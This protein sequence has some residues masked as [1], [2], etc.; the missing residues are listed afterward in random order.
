M[1]KAFP[2][3]DGPPW[4]VG[5]REAQRRAGV[6]E[7]MERFGGRGIRPSMPDQH[8]QFFSQLPFL[9]IGSIDSSGLP[10]AS[11]LT[12]QPGFATT[13]DERTLHVAARPP[14]G[15]P[16]RVALRPD[17]ML[18]ILGI[19]LA[20][21]RRNRINGRVMVVDNLGFSVTVDQIFG[22]CPQYIQRLEAI[23]ALP[24]NRVEFE[25]FVV[26]VASARTVIQEADTFFVATFSQAEGPAAS[27]GVDVSHRGG[28]PGFVDVAADGTVT[29]PDFAGNR[30]FNTLG[31]LAV[32]PVAGLLFIDFAS[33]DLLQ[34]SGSTDVVWEGDEVARFSGAERLWRVHPSHGRWLRGGFPLRLASPEPSPQVL[35]T[36]TWADIR[37][38]LAGEGLAAKPRARAS[39]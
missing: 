14:E 28:R 19:E 7:R 25:P 35:T 38:N 29:V 39:G 32:N 9:L 22:N 17:A 21:R 37:D 31:N 15:D 1:S 34:F 16:L 24:S 36:G 4:H 10:W 26:L 2:H 23:A 27:H 18:G 33:G 20:T 5:E 30:F 13:P 11:L 8:R 6:A 12:G 3:P